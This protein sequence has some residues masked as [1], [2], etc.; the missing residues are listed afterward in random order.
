MVSLFTALVARGVQVPAID[1]R[2]EGH[3][4]ILLVV[5]PIDQGPAASAPASSVRPTPEGI[6]ASLDIET[7]S[8]VMASDDEVKALK[9][10]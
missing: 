3:T 5:D 7:R 8:A 2:I 1:P 4:D 6:Q 9:K 10:N